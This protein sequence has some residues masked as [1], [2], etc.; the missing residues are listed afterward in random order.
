MFQE[1]NSTW[2][3]LFSSLLTTRE[4][5]KLK[6]S[7]RS[8]WVV[9][10]NV[11]DNEATVEEWKRASAV[12]KVAFMG[13]GL[14]H[15]IG[16]KFATIKSNDIILI[17]RR[18]KNAPD[19]VGFGVVQGE[20]RTSLAGFRPPKGD[21]LSSFSALRKLG[22]F[23]PKS[24]FPKSLRVKNALG[25]S[26]A[27][28]K[29]RPETD[30]RRICEWME[31]ELRKLQ[32]E[33]AGK[34][35]ETTKKEKAELR[36]L[37]ERGSFEYEVRSRRRT[38]VATKREKKLVLRYIKWLKK[39]GRSFRVAVYKKLRCDVYEPETKNLIE[40]KS[41]SSRENIRMAV[42]QLLDYSYQGRETFGEANLAVLLPNKPEWDDIEWLTC[43][44]ISVIWEERG[45][46]VDN[47]NGLFTESSS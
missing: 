1:L 13:W 10:P 31:I 42:G 14:D 11:R 41:S 26:A 5:H 7:A 40:A 27:L 44:R 29:L 4:K 12:W 43:H 22:P 47:A 30:H 36:K 2:Y 19:V 38:K 15:P 9:S 8:F 33:R 16:K 24:S 23:I 34:G 32:T 37:D 28:R 46:F 39:W 6:V 17:A 45:S 25:Q 18:H 20:C 3:G 35:I 21:R